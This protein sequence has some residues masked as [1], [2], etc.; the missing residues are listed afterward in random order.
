MKKL[1]F[2]KMHGTGNDFVVLYEKDVEELNINLTESFIQKIC[3]R[4]FWIGSDGLLVVASSKKADFR[5]DMYNPDGS[6]AEMCGNGIRCYMKYLLENR[7]TQKT[8]INVETLA[9]IL[10][11]VF[12]DNLFTVNMGSPTKIKDIAFKNKIL[13]DRFFLKSEGRDF[14]FTPVSMGNPHAVIFLQNEALSSFDVEKYGMPIERNI[15]IFP[16]RTNVEFIDVVSEKEISMR[17]WERGAGETLSCWTWAC[18]S[19]VAGILAWFLNK[20]EF[21]KVNIRGGTLFVKWNGEEKDSVIMQG[22]AE[23]TFE[24]FYYVK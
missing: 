17:V 18:A 24:G 6:R 22:W 12:E 4:N 13:W 21:I 5:Y 11:V 16:Q 23:V 20:W 2:V 15:E 14:L 19:V 9:W 8:K 1:P 3:N 10:E 7:L